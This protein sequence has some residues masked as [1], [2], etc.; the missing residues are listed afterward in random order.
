M[1]LG[2][3][4]IDTDTD[5][6]DKGMVSEEE[7]S[8]PSAGE[9]GDDREQVEA[10]YKI[11][12]LPGPSSRRGKRSTSASMPMPTSGLGGIERSGED[13]LGLSLGKDN[14]LGV[15][16]TAGASKMAL[17]AKK[18]KAVPVDVDDD[19]EH[20]LS[21]KALARRWVRPHPSP[22]LSGVQTSP[23]ARNTTHFSPLPPLIS[24][25][26]SHLLF[27]HVFHLEDRWTNLRELGQ[28]AYGL[29]ISAEDSISGEK[30][31]IKLLTRVFDKVILARRCL[32]EITLLRHLNGHEN[33]SW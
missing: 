1:K 17:A 30:I 32:R 10:G 25:Y 2:S 21:E 3:E 13:H 11:D 12:G 24:G 15:T 6:R 16:T 19:V 5:E 14:G 20:P 27:K 33:V 9:M 8:S 18:G 29:V 22:F 7:E 31:A 28:G 26:L 4:A 23:L